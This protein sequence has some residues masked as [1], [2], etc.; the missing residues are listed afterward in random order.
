MTWLTRILEPEVMDSAEEARDYDAM[1]HS[2][3]NRVFVAD[4]L[5]VWNVA[6]PILDLGT[7]TAQI[8]IEL[9]RRDDRVV[10]TAID[11]AA[12]MLALAKRNVDA[13]GLHER[14]RLERADA[15]RLPFADDA[16][17]AVISNSIV[18]HIPEPITVLAEMV[19]VL[20]PDGLLFV[21]DLLRPTDESTLRGLMDVYAA[22]ASEHARQMFADSLHAALSLEE[23]LELV[24]GLGFDPAGVRQTTDRHWT[25]VAWK[26]GAGREK[27]PVPY[28]ANGDGSMSVSEAIS[29]ADALL[30]GEPL[31]AGESDPRWQAI[32]TVG[33]YIEAEPEAVW[34]FIRRWGGHAQEDLRD[35]IAICLLEDLLRY[36]FAAYF[37]RVEELALTESLFG[38]TFVR[39]WQLGQAEE[40]GN[41]ERFQALRIRLMESET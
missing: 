34:S 36:H 21:R 6:V 14:V 1:D 37:P 10:V 41:A 13:A 4:F 25:W 16:F 39:C 11:A 33:E 5:E 17:A 26:A 7:G 30:P 8:P 3:V 40:P 20:A 2:A 18:H 15:K 31:A 35:A 12:H 9:C 23:M 24:A 32:I 27:E 29:E 38:D 22:G 28:Y 19:R